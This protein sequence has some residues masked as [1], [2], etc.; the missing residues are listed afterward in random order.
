MDTF[1][2]F[3][4]Q[5]FCHPPCFHFVVFPVF[6]QTVTHGV[7]RRIF[8]TKL[9]HTGGTVKFFRCSD[10]FGFPESSQAY[11]RS[12]MFK[13]MSISHFSPNLETIFHPKNSISWLSHIFRTFAISISNLGREIEISKLSRIWHTVFLCCNLYKVIIA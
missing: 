6:G 12:F 4:Y 9:L 8:G 11:I 5:V 1:H 2:T 3:H 7:H 13:I 10:F